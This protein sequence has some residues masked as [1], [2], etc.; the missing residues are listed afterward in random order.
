MNKNA[1][2]L[3]A[4]FPHTIPV[5]LGYLFIGIAFGV[6]FENKG[7]NF[8]WA[9]IM[10]T[11]VYAGSM[12]FVA[13]NFFTGGISLISV[14][15]ITFMVNIRHIFYGLSMIDKF[16]E[17]GNIKPYMIFSLT[18]ETYSLLCLV[19]SPKDVDRNLFLFFIA[20]LNQIYW[21]VGSFIG[22]VAGS[23]ITFN[24]KGIDFAMTALFTV[25]FVEQWLFCKSHIPAVIGVMISLICLIIFGAN[26]FLLPSMILIIL[27]LTIFRNIIELKLEVKEKDGEII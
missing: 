21:V 20:F 11:L 27:I 26:N 9:I 18:D 15:L 4:A 14:A 12:Q 10:S 25:I 7:Y 23:M 2:A 8:I 24:S 3:K 16:K 6:L 13:V 1:K 22:S 19:D 5:M 17:M